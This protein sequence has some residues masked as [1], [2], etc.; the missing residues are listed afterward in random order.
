MKR[1]SGCLAV[2]LLLAGIPLFSAMPNKIVHGIYKSS[3]SN[4]EIKIEKG[5]YIIRGDQIEIRTDRRT[6]VCYTVFSRTSFGNA[7]EL[8]CLCSFE[9]IDSPQ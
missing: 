6:S 8:F 4:T 7:H 2:L 3:V 1:I 9:N 5:I